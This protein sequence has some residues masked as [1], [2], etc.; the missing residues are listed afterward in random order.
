MKKVEKF[1]VRIV[2]TG[3]K[4]GRDDCL[5]NKEAP[6]VEFYD[7]RF[8]DPAFGERGQFVSRYYVS[9]LL[10]RQPSV[11]LCLHGGVY[12]W[13]VSAEGMEQVLAYINQ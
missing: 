8:T 2:N 12:E 4:Y 6:M 13:A 1:N 9:A 11:G 3:D 5:V 10:E 7:T